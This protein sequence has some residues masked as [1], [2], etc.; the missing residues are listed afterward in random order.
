MYSKTKISLLLLYRKCYVFLNSVMRPSISIRHYLYLSKILLCSTIVFIFSSV[1]SQ[2]QTSKESVIEALNQKFFLKKINEIEFLNSRKISSVQDWNHIADELSKDSPYNAESAERMNQQIADWLNNPDRREAYLN[3]VELNQYIQWLYAKPEKTNTSLQSVDQFRIDSIDITADWIRE[4]LNNPD[5][6]QESSDLIESPTNLNEVEISFQMIGIDMPRFQPDSVE[7]QIAFY[8]AQK[9]MFENPKVYFA[10][11]SALEGGEAWTV[12]NNFENSE[13]LGET[14]TRLFPEISLEIGTIG[15]GLTIGTEEWRQFLIG[16]NDMDGMLGS[17]RLE[18]MAQTWT[19]LMFECERIPRSCLIHTRADQNQAYMRQALLYA[20]ENSNFPEIETTE[21]IKALYPDQAALAQIEQFVE[22]YKKDK[23]EIVQEISDFMKLTFEEH[24]KVF[25]EQDKQKSLESMKKNSPYYKNKNSVLLA[26]DNEIQDLKDDNRELAEKLN[27]PNLTEQEKTKFLKDIQN[28]HQALEDFQKNRDIYQL[29]AGTRQLH[30]WL[31]LGISVARHIPGG[32]NFVKAGVAGQAVLQAH[33]AIGS[34]IIK[35]ALD[36]TKLTTAVDAVGVVL[37]IVSG[38]PSTDQVMMNHLVELRK[39][40]AM[41]IQYLRELNSDVKIVNQKL[42]VVIKIL[43]LSHNKIIGRIDQLQDDLHRV[44]NEILAAIENAKE[45]GQQMAQA[46]LTQYKD[47]A[48]ILAETLGTYEY[49]NLLK[50]VSRCKSLKEEYEQT[51]HIETLIFYNSCVEWAE[52]IRFRIDKELLSLYIKSMNRLDIEPF[53]TKKQLINLSP[54]DVTSQFTKRV[55]ERAGLIMSMSSWLDDELKKLSAEDLQWTEHQMFMSRVEKNIYHPYHFDESF[56]SY[57]NLTTFLPPPR[58]YAFMADEWDESP[59]YSNKH[60]YNMCSTAQFI[61]R[62]AKSNRENLGKAW[63]VYTHFL[64][65]ISQEIKTQFDDLLDEANKNRDTSVIEYI[66]DENYSSIELLNTSSEEIVQKALKRSFM[67]NNYLIRNG[68]YKTVRGDCLQFKKLG[69]K[70]SSK[71]SKKVPYI[72]ADLHIEEQRTHYDKTVRR[73]KEE[74]KCWITDIDGHIKGLTKGSQFQIE[75]Y[76]AFK[77]IIGMQE[78]ELRHMCLFSR[79]SLDG[80]GAG[81]VIGGI[82]GG[83]LGFIVDVVTLGATVGT[84]TVGGASVGAILGGVWDG[85][86]FAFSLC[87]TAELRQTV[88]NPLV[89]TGDLVSQSDFLGR[90]YY[91]KK[92]L[93]S[94]LQSYTATQSNGESTIVY[95]YHFACKKKACL[96]FGTK[97]IADRKKWIKAANKDIKN[98]KELLRSETE[99]LFTLSPFENVREFYKAS[100]ALD[101]MARMGYGQNLESQPRLLEYLY[102]LRAFLVDLRKTGDSKL[103][104]E[105]ILQ[106]FGEFD[107]SG[108]KSDETALPVDPVSTGEP[109]GWGLPWQRHKAF[110]VLSNREYFTHQV[111]RRR[112]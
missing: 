96:K 30:S 54:S 84:G 71:N 2:E 92:P 58:D 16:K 99:T 44:E 66:I 33:K 97:K 106:I 88:W 85:Q 62:V 78:K 53:V 89:I 35:G 52:H 23:K 59:M 42:D 9:A 6:P 19:A 76:V 4:K 55:E 83:G 108:M 51:N 80:M 104:T 72:E 109:M 79:R 77:N 41:V 43:E 70:D 21:D 24:I 1:G 17:S 61:D 28:N 10:L 14:M 22:S 63:L 47:D 112:D 46:N 102:N 100:L 68:F 60:L 64:K 107:T 75:E 81:A 48:D 34:M 110:E 15:F 93:T 8:Q 36:P 27:S 101:T 57:V 105:Q 49:V 91:N 13:K 25:Q 69:E 87:E 12:F 11:R 39:G 94:Y 31:G 67:T 90:V 37:Q 56:G 26:I 65:N 7:Q 20:Q 111:C 73:L 50:V 86:E 103:K 98:I 40:Q 74:N 38:V 3:D 18:D 95:P 45:A 29:E 5:A 82:I 32:E